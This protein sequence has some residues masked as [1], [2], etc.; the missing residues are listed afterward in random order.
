MP[1]AP[2]PKLTFPQIGESGCACVFTDAA[3]EAGTGFGG[4][5][6]VEEG[7]SG[8]PV[9]LFIE[10]RWSEASLR[11]LR[12]DEWSMPAGEMF[13]ATREDYRGGDAEAEGNCIYGVFL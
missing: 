7:P 8:S 9:F 11:K 12:R 13:G 5:M 6:I 3:R 10:Q 4:F 2:K 1:L